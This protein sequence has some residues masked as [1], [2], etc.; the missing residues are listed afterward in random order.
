M[1]HRKVFIVVVVIVIGDVRM[2]ETNYKNNNYRNR[3]MTAKKKEVKGKHV[4][5]PRCGHTWEYKGNRTEEQFIQCPACR[6]VRKLKE[7]IEEKEKG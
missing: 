7:F 2:R 3:N 6:I 4:K 1:D 5:C